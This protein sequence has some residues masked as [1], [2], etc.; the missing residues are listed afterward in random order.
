MQESVQE[1][2]LRVYP[3]WIEVYWSMSF[4]GLFK[5]AGWNVISIQSEED[6]GDIDLIPD[7]D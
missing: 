4:G 1:Q 5:P 3:D 7:L 2:H 6:D